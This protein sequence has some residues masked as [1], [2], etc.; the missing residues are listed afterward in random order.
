MRKLLNAR[1]LIA[2][3]ASAASI[4]FISAFL[5]PSFGDESKENK[6][7]IYLTAWPFIAARVEIEN[8]D[9]SHS[10]GERFTVRYVVQYSSSHVNLDLDTAFNSIV[11]APFELEGRPTILHRKIGRLPNNEGADVWEYVFE[12]KLFIVNGLVDRVYYLPQTSVDYIALD[13][14]ASGLIE[15]KNDWPVNITR[16]VTDIDVAEL[17][18]VKGPVKDNTSS[19]SD[20]FGY[21]GVLFV[22]A[23]IF[24][25]M[26]WIYGP[27]F[28]QKKKTS[29]QEMS[30][31]EKLNRFKDE[32]WLRKD[33]AKNRMI[34]L[35]NLTLEIARV[36]RNISTASF[37]ELFATGELGELFNKAFSHSAD[38][39]VS[40]EDVD[41]ALDK[42]FAKTLDIK[43]F[44][45]TGSNI[46]KERR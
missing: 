43:E 40:Y 33:S 25:S 44:T 20:K 1:T 35:Q 11:F 10:L 18:N 4:I 37:F 34:A 16:N 15:V 9:Y 38:E 5:T 13:N 14:V 29:T 32:I 7:E 30:L 45:D 39:D 31:A 23:L 21:A 41:A 3:L 24:L 46:K 19:I 28:S 17:R 36:F 6:D 2:V 8:N 26:L 42:V 22:V 27:K 12:V